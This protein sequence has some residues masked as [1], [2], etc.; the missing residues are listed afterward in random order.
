MSQPGTRGTGGTFT[1]I[2]AATLAALRRCVGSRS[3]RPLVAVTGSL[4]VT[5]VVAL[6]VA[7]PADRTIGDLAGPV[8]ILMS[9]TVPFTG[10]LA[11]HDLR[12]SSGTA[13]L[14]PALLAAALLAVAVGA[15][16]FVACLVA[17]VVAPS[18]TAQGRWDHAATVLVGCVLVQVLAQF[19][20]TGLGLLVRPVVVACLAT[21]VVPLGLWLLLGTVDLLRPGR[22]WLTP[23]AVGQH[24]LS[25]RMSALAWI[26]WLVVFLLWAVGLNAVGAAR[27]RQ[28]RAQR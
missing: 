3:G 10:V 21:I 15:F 4:G 8:Q 18:G 6:T 5:A 28:G 14:L 13:R 22:E 16:G 1:G 2:G 27:L 23:Y 26:R 17:L 7:S 25:G 12:R 24:L 9:V 11:A 20:G 19:V